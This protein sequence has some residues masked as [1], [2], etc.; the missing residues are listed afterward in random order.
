M[1]CRL[2][3]FVAVPG[4]LVPVLRS[5]LFFLKLGLVELRCHEQRLILVNRIGGEVIY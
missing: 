5:V 3:R 1:T 4:I 2:G